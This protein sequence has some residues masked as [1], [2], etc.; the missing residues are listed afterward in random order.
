MYKFQEQLFFLCTH[1]KPYKERNLKLQEIAGTLELQQIYFLFRYQA[2][3]LHLNV[4][5]LFF[6]NVLYYNKKQ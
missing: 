3:I 6:K 1:L 5:S 2:P 4:L